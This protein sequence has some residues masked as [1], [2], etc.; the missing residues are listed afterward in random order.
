[1]A[2]YVLGVNLISFVIT[3]HDKRAASKQAWRI[4]E[5]TLHLL[6]LLSGWPAGMLAQQL[7][8]HKTQKT[9]FKWI[10]LF[11]ILINILVWSG[12]A[13]YQFQAV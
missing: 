1:M 3:W 13:Y 2:I 7:F 12:F 10:Y 11:S 5:R 9:P 4:K 6:G 8:R